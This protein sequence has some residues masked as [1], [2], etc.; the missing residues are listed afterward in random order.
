MT[1]LRSCSFARSA[2]FR[3]KRIFGDNATDVIDD[4]PAEAIVSRLTKLLQFLA[5]QHPGEGWD[6][7]LDNGAP[8]WNRIAIAGHSQGA[9]MA[10]FIAKRQVVAR[11]VLLSGPVDFSN[12]GKVLAPWIASASATPP[13]RWYGLYH[14]H[15]LRAGLLEQ[16]YGVLRIP[17]AHVRALDSEPGAPPPRPNGDPYH[18]SVIS[19]RT[20]PRDST[21]APSYAGDWAF[22]LGHSP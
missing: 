17:P 6:A 22:I 4:T 18:V 14:T 12:P 11:V 19:D 15:E 9:G 21:G 13:D 5:R 1:I 20:T 3:E 2:R 10:A 8:R 16:S 7:Y